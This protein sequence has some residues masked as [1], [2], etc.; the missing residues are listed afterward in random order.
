M[1]R[2]E[3]LKGWKQQGEMYVAA[4]QSFAQGQGVDRFR[5]VYDALKSWKIG[6]RGVVKDP[7]WVWNRLA[8]INPELSRRRLSRVRRS[9]WGLIID[10][11]DSMKDVKTGQKPS[12][13]AISKFLHFF[14]PRLF[15]I[16][17]REVVDEFVFGHQWLRRLRDAVG[18]RTFEESGIDVPEWMKDY[19]SLLA[20]ASE[21]L[22]ENPGIMRAFA[23]W[24][25]DIPGTETHPRDVTSFEATAI[26]R[27][28]I[29]L[30]E[31]PP[32]RAQV[33]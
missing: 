31:L 3:W 21:T 18:S 23:D 19:L 14:N 20:L 29:G 17:D 16:C 6:R 10:A 26:E 7:R 4:E 32:A 28:L 33:T 11:V 15:V 2:P 25:K 13:M 12:L 22:R 1:H 8:G 30:A 9:D 24:V 27:F 5:E